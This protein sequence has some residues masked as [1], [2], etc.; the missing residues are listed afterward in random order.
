MVSTTAQPTVNESRPVLTTN[1][2]STPSIE[3]Q[4]NEYKAKVARLEAELKETKQQL[5]SAKSQLS[6]T[7][8]QLESTAKKLEEKAVINR[9][10]ETV[11]TFLREENERISAEAE[12]IVQHYK[13][14][15]A[16]LHTRQAS[17]LALTKSNKNLGMK[18]LQL[19]RTLSEKSF[20][21]MEENWDIE[22]DST[23]RD[24]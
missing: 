16:S 22:D 13:R 20:N 3:E 23:S 19:E 8:Y 17:L 10:L 5:N 18:I 15:K 9:H 6:D 14:M 2:E 11:A 1:T 12:E 24:E 4:L 7:T 21:A